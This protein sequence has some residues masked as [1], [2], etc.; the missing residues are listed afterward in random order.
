MSEDNERRDASGENTATDQLLMQRANSNTNTETS[1]NNTVAISQQGSGVAAVPQPAAPVP[2]RQSG[3]EVFF[4]RTPQ[5]PATNST[6]TPS[7]DGSGAFTPGNIFP[8]GSK[9]DMYV[10]ITE[11]QIYNFNQTNE[12]FWLL[13]NLEYGNWKAGP[14]RDGTFTK[15]GQIPISETVQNN[16]SLYL[17]V[18]VTEH[19]YTPNPYD[20]DAYSRRYS[21]SKTKHIEFDMLSG[22]YYP[23][24]YLNDYWNLLSDYDPINNTIDALN[25]TLTYSPLQLWKWQMYISQHLRQ[26]WY[27]NLLGD[28][29]SDD[30]QDAMKRALIETNP[31]LLIITICVSIV[32]TVFEILA[33]K[34]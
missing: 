32:H 6:L 5:N 17:H 34:N 23:V 3:W 7:F 8:K 25:L 2:R 4:R 26:S 9:L 10:Y 13:E 15:Y 14:N 20:G 16:G 29:E 12:P 24:L 21:F 27:G 33:F 18:F 19:G 31:Y 30:D 22:K 1:N 28:D 11:D